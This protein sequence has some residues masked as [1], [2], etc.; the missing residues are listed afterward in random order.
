MRYEGK[1]FKSNFMNAVGSND[2]ELQ[3][4]IILDQIAEL[5][6]TNV[7]EVVDSLVKSGVS[8]PAK[9]TKIDVIDAVSKSLYSNPSFQKNI[10]E[11]IQKKTTNFSNGVGTDTAP[12]PASEVG[13]TVGGFLSS[14]LSSVFGIISSV[15]ERKAAEANAKASL[16][17]KIFGGQ[18]TKT[19]YVP[20]IIIGGVLLVGGI[21][22]VVILKGK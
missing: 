21:I 10:S 20:I 5:I 3:K 15:Q 9:Y 8:V 6:K 17:D 12:T 2:S 11:L 4:D 19:D 1:S 14:S 7:S 18:K 13:K 22:A 16:M